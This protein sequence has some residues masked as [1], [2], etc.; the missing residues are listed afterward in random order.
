[1]LVCRNAVSVVESGEGRSSDADFV[2]RLTPLTFRTTGS[3]VCSENRGFSVVK[4]LSRA[5]ICRSVAH[6]AGDGGQCGAQG[7]GPGAKEWSVRGHDFRISWTSWVWAL[8]FSQRSAKPSSRVR[9][10]PSPQTRFWRKFEK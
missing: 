2:G 9:F 8:E 10:P 1:M 7:K 4:G 6:R 3:R 5:S